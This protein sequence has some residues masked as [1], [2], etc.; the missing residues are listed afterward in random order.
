MRWM[1]VPQSVAIAVPL[2]L[3]T[4]VLIPT[5]FASESQ[6]RRPSAGPP[7]WG[8]SC[9]TDLRDYTQ[10]ELHGP[11]F[12]MCGQF[13]IDADDGFEDKWVDVYCSVG[14]WDF[15]MSLVGQHVEAWG[16]DVWHDDCGWGDG[17][18]FCV[19]KVDVPTSVSEP[20]I[21]VRTVSWGVMKASYR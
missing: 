14:H 19:W 11:I 13:L 1:N 3:L 20:E 7:I 18:A 5:A 4:A 8:Q 6:T 15:W 16:E 12:D 17:Y 2:L 21:L 9:P 10:G